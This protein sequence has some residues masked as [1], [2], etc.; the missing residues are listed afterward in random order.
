MSKEATQNTIGQLLKYGAVRDAIHVAVAPVGA[1][2]N[3]LHPGQRIG[4]TPE[5]EYEMSYIAA[6]DS[7]CVGIVDP[8]LTQPVKPYETFWLF[9]LPNTITALSHNWSHP[10]FASL[11]AVPTAL[12][13]CLTCNN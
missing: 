5:D 1:G 3:T 8:F 13:D 9:L 7:P 11:T 6:P 2:E 12:T 10:A 4:V